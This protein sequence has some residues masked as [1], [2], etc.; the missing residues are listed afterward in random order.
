MTLREQ[1]LTCTACALSSKTGVHPVPWSGPAPAELAVIG[2]APGA[3]ENAKGEPL[4]GPAGR[5][6]QKWWADL[7]LDWEK[8]AKLNVV[9]CYPLGTPDE[10]S[11]RACTTNLWA[12]LD[13]IQPK[14]V[15][16]IGA[17]A[18]G[19]FWPGVPLKTARGQWWNEDEVFMGVA[20]YHPA[21]VLRQRSMQA[22]VNKDL[23]MFKL[24]VSLLREGRTP[25]RVYTTCVMCGKDSTKRYKGLAFCDWC[26]SPEEAIKLC[27]PGTERIM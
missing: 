24:G 21:F 18:F 13:V 19:C 4:V 27:F 3:H 6:V 23:A 8:T 11:I 10:E 14:A 17:V 20:T 25:P 22:E 7:G 9:S 2:E 15:L 16:V 1:I 26:V 5:L 12:Q